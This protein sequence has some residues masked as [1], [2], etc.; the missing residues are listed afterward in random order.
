MDKLLKR[1]EDLTIL[2]TLRTDFNNVKHLLKI[3]SL[4]DLIWSIYDK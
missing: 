1:K 4:N 2:K 3:D